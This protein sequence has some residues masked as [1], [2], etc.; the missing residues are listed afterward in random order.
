VSGQHPVFKFRCPSCS[1]HHISVAKFNTWNEVH[2]V[3]RRFCPKDPNKEKNILVHMWDLKV[4]GKTSV[5][6][7]TAPVAPFER[8]PQ[9]EC[10]ECFATGEYVAFTTVD[11]CSTCF[12]KPKPC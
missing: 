12:P 7:P 8:I 3:L 6:Q 2:Q 11:Q 4:D 1:L 5:K 10:K 9:Y